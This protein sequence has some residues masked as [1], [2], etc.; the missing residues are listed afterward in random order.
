MVDVAAYDYD[1]SSSMADGSVGF[2]LVLTQQ[3]EVNV[4]IDP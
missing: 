2:T 4:F 1:F 3:P